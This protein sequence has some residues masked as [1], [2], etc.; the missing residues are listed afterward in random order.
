MGVPQYMPTPTR[1][2]V[3]KHVLLRRAIVGQPHL[4]SCW[5]YVAAAARMTKSHVG[6]VRPRCPWNVLAQMRHLEAMFNPCTRNRP[7]G[8]DP[9][10]TEWTCLTYRYRPNILFPDGA[11]PPQKKGTTITM[12]IISCLNWPLTQT[13][14]ADQS[15]PPPPSQTL[16]KKP[17]KLHSF[18]TIPWGCFIWTRDDNRLPPG[19]IAATAARSPAAAPSPAEPALWTSPH[20]RPATRDVATLGVKPQK[21]Q[22]HIQNSRT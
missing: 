18:G 20:H 17:G 12:T 7:F 13:I 22:L 11:S 21:G 8:V 5:S 4:G 16:R 2:I 9:P 15:L 1:S 14:L 19:F 3:I 10:K 6:D